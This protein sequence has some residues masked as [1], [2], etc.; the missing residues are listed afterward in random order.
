MRE[1]GALRDGTILRLTLEEWEQVPRVHRRGA[2]LRARAVAG[3]IVERPGGKMVVPSSTS[4]LSN[5]DQ[6]NCFPAKAPIQGPVRTLAVEL[7]PFDVSLRAVAPGIVD[8][9]MT[10][11]VAGRPG[12]SLEAVN[13]Q[14][15]ERPSLGRPGQPEDIALVIAFPWSKQAA[16]FF[17][18]MLCV[19]GAGPPERWISASAQTL[20]RVGP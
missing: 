16:Y 1:P 19:N 6:A 12:L 8:T 11:A 5:P 9:A 14:Q 4:S 20:L 17:G 13:R 2:F 15:R 10:R 7:G 3:Q 18:Q